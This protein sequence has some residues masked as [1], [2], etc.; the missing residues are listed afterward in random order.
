MTLI[1]P[2]V[3]KTKEA[4]EYVGGRPVWEDLVKHYGATLKPF[5][6]TAERGNSYYRRETIDKVLLLAEVEGKLVQTPP[7]TI[8]KTSIGKH[9]TKPPTDSSASD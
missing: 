8:S 9:V 2:A 7:K 4:Q 1:I 3:L 5:R 6:S